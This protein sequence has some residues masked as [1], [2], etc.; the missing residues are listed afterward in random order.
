M[1]TNDGLFCCLYVLFLIL[2]YIDHV[3]MGFD[4]ATL[5]FAI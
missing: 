3:V 4:F 5:T 1:M 2:V